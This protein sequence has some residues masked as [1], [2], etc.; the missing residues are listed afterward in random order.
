[1]KRRS[2][3]SRR[4]PILL[5]FLAGTALV[6]LSI[7]YNKPG[8]S[9]LSRFMK[10]R[11]AK[12]P[13]RP[14]P[15]LAI[16]LDDVGG[17]DSAVNEIFTLPNQITLAI[18]PNHAR[19]REIAE[20][21][22]SR[23]YELMLHLPMESEANESPETEELRTGMNT[24]EVSRILT[25]MLLTVPHAV[26]V[27]N[28]QGSRATSDAALMQELMP[29][30]EER[31]LYFIDSRTTRATLAYE[32]AQRDGVRS[33]FRNVPFLDDV[34]EQATIQ[35]ELERAIHGAKEKGQAIVIAHP[36]PETL[37]V[38]QQMLP[39]LPAQGL[40]LVHASA[41]VHALANY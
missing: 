40:E 2:P 10:P 11:L 26:G 24:R 17:D 21:A 28:H 18:L 13:G 27:N 29:L 9:L 36:H 20:Q 25:E 22:Y 39:E 5:L 15:K 7:N 35:Q 16:I 3:A 14:L 31:R 23:G 8:N 4:I 38:L 19:S 12:L 37:E 1:M 30:L 6:F 33:A 32:V 41:L 34:H